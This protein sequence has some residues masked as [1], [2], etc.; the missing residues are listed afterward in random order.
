MARAAKAALVLV[1][2]VGKAPAAEA[3]LTATLVAEPPPL[4]AC[5]GG[6]VRLRP[7]A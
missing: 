3:A 1:D 5:Y 4:P 6:T 7:R 2:L